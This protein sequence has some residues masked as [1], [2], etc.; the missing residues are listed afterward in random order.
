M[1]AGRRGVSGRVRGMRAA[2]PRRLASPLAAAA[3]TLRR[4]SRARGRE[5]QPVLVE[6][7]AEQPLAG[8]VRRHR[9]AELRHDWIPGVGSELVVRSAECGRG[10]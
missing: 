7:G 4:W 9:G 3:T 5:L 1:S 2:R 8:S 10:L 6:R